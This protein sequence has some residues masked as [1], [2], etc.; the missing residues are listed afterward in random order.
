MLFEL[1]FVKRDCEAPW[2]SVKYNSTLPLRSLW[3]TTHSSLSERLGRESVV[4]PLL[5][6]I[7]SAPPSPSY[8]SK[9]K[10]SKL[11]ERNEWNK[12]QFGQ[13]PATGTSFGFTS[14]IGGGGGAQLASVAGSHSV[15]PQSSIAGSHSV[16]PQFSIAGS[17][18]GSGV[19]QTSLVGSHFGSGVPQSSIAGSHSE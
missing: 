15:S 10:T 5:R 13:E 11:P 9:R 4:L 17:H 16:S 6:L 18:S 7:A 12:I 1:V 2:L 8:P 14:V 3:N 19:L